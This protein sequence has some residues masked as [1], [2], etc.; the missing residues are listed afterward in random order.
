LQHWLLSKEKHSLDSTLFK[1]T[2]HTRTVLTPDH[3]LI[4]PDGHV[5]SALPGWGGAMGVILI[6]PAMGARLAQTLVFLDAGSQHVF[7]PASGIEAV[8]Y[9]MEGELTCAGEAL[10]EGSYGFLPAGESLEFAAQSAVK[11]VVFEKRYAAKFGVEAPRRVFGHADVIEGKPFMGDPDAT[12]QVLLPETPEFDLAMNIFTYQPGAT[13]P[14]AETHV[15]EHGLLMLDGMGI[16]RLNERWYPVAAGDC[17]WMAPYCP[18]WFGALGKAPS[19]YI[20]YKDVNR[21]AMEAL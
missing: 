2:G 19:R 18:Q 1:R 15:M 9:V 17:I 21:D 8:F 6:S 11:L 20:Y 14:F 16:Y 10:R 5:L 3:A 4:A 7:Q 13:L 12:L